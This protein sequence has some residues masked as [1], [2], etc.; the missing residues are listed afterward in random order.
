MTPHVLKKPSGNSPWFWILRNLGPS[1][2]QLPSSVCLT[3]PVASREGIHC[4]SHF[5]PVI[6]ETEKQSGLSQKHWG[7]PIW[8]QFWKHVLWG[9]FSLPHF[10]AYWILHGNSKT[11]SHCPEFGLSFL[12]SVIFSKRTNR[13]YFFSTLFKGYFS[14]NLCNFEV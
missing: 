5:L 10:V 2:S 7:L 4:S 13:S 9:H 12:Y 3:C 14:W 1:L 11:L 8:N 6:N